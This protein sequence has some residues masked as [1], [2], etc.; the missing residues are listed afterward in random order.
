VN[1]WDPKVIRGSMGSIFRLPVIQHTSWSTLTDLVLEENAAVYL[2]DS[3]GSAEKVK[4]FSD[5]EYGADR[6]PIVL[7]VGGETKGL[8]KEA[9]GLLKIGQ[10]CSKIH[11]PLAH[12]VESLNVGGAVAVLLFEIRRQWLLKNATHRGVLINSGG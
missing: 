9:A 6:R 7:V 5:E 11:I 8:S 10:Q 3:R 1:V 12:G 2:A 4:I